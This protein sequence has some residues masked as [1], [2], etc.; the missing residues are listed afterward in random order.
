VVVEVDILARRWVGAEPARR[1]LAAIASGVHD[2]VVLDDA[3][4]R[5]A[6]EIDATFADVNLGLVDCS[7]MALAE[8]RRLP[9]FTFD[10]RAFRAVPGP[11]RG[12][13]WR[14]VVEESDLV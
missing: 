10:F 1:F 5:R 7:V 6:L 12:K 11:A 14:L 2:R 9:V 8:E 13:N 4:W 3:L